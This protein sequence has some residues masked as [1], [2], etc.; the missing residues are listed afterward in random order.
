[1]AVDMATH[2]FNDKIKAEL[3]HLGVTAEPAAEA[4][5]G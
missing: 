5:A 4:A 3:A 1:V 2:G